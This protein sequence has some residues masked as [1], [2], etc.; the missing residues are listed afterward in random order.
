[1]TEIEFGRDGNT[2]KL[3]ISSDGKVINTNIPVDATVSRQHCKLV[4]SDSSEMTLYNLNHE[5][6]T[7]LNGVSISKKTFTLDDNTVVVLGNNGCTLQLKK[8]LKEIGL[9][10]T[11]S[12]A[13]LKDIVAKYKEEKMK[14]QISLG[15]QNAMRGLM[16]AFMALGAILGFTDILPENAKIIPSVFSFVFSG[17]FGYKGFISAS[18]NPKRQ[19]ELDSRYHKECVCPN[20]ECKHFLPGEYDDILRA[21]ACPWCKSKFKE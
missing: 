15:R 11:Y 7:L 13:H 6:K 5:N 21:G 3:K 17:Y 4:I 18:N 10:Q 2:G 9:K 12:I 8:L 16:P 19:M 20:P 1:M 14:M